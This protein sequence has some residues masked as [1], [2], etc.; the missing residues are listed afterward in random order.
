M[1]FQGHQ[2]VSMDLFGYLWISIAICGYQTISFDTNKY[3][4]NGMSSQ[5][6]QQELLRNMYSNKVGDVFSQMIL[7]VYTSK[8]KQRWKLRMLR[9]RRA[10]RGYKWK[11]GILQSARCGPWDGPFW[12]RDGLHFRA[13]HR[14]QRMWRGQDWKCLGGLI[15][16]RVVNSEYKR[17]RT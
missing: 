14:W 15:E 4:E 5:A 17:S 13:L 10:E 7:R 8:R 3:P 11:L 9:P 1:D 2:W 12:G 6:N 16:A